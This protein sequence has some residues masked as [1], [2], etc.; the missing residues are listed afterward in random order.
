MPGGPTESA[1]R[2]S[3]F[4]T[5]DEFCFVVGWDDGGLTMFEGTVYCFCCFFIVLLFYET[6]VAGY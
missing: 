3:T 1:K 4:C 6:D 2:E 5:N